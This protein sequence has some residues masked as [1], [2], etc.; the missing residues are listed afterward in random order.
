MLLSPHRLGGY[1]TERYL[2]LI[3]TCELEEALETS[4]IPPRFES[5]RVGVGGSGVEIG[6]TA[7]TPTCFLLSLSSGLKLSRLSAE[8]HPPARDL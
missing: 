1:S 7:L 5:K 8:P 4:V 3:P 6:P 2:G